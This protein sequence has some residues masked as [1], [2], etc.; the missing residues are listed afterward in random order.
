MSASVAE[1]LV[2]VAPVKVKFVVLR[3]VEVAL[4]MV[5]FVAMISSTVRVLVRLRFSILAVVIVVD[6]TVVVAK[7]LVP[8]EVIAAT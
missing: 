5:P 7:V 1:M 2:P 4:V 3:F 6:A 8:V